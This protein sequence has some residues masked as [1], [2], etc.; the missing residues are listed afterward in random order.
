MLQ[1]SLEKGHRIAIFTTLVGMKEEDA[2]ITCGLLRQYTDKIHKICIHLPDAANH[3]PGWK[4]S[5]T[6]DYALEQFLALD[7]EK[8][9]LPFV[10]MTMDGQGRIHPD[11]TSKH[12]PLT[13]SRF[14]SRGGALGDGK[15]KSPEINSP[16]VCGRSIFYD[17]NS[18]LPNG[19]IALC[20]MD[21]GL[22]HILGNI[23]LEEYQQIQEK[24][25]IFAKNAMF[26]VDKSICKYCEYAIEFVLNKNQDWRKKDSP[27]YNLSQL[28]H[29][30]KKTIKFYYSK[31]IQRWKSPKYKGISCFSVLCIY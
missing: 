7:R 1:Y 11:V 23:L 25:T 24:K 4:K 27:E 20:A 22:K 6:W 8:S 9:L 30:C 15:V 31:M 12:I 28:M 16:V 21:Y 5:K 14:N 26:G 19:D 17:R 18:L 29:H 13:D 3:M 10:W 2:D